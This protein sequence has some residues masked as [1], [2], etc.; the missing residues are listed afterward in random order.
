MKGPFGR[1]KGLLFRKKIRATKNRAGFK[2]YAQFNRK[3]S[4]LGCVFMIKKMSLLL[5]GILVSSTVGCSFIKIE[6]FPKAKIAHTKWAEVKSS[7]EGIYEFQHRNVRLIIRND[8][9]SGCLFF[10]G[11]PLLPV[12]PLFRKSYQAKFGFGLDV[13]SLSGRTKIDL[14]KIRIQTSEG[15]SMQPS[16]IWMWRTG[17]YY[18]KAKEIS[19]QQVEVSKE[20]VSFSINFDARESELVKY[21]A[22]DLGEIAINDENIEV[23]LL[24]YHKG[25][26]W[27]F[28][29][30]AIG[31][32]GLIYFPK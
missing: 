3:P 14:S 4:T 16:G 5:I 28:A 6:T 13:E 15:R 19:I 32:E 31:S 21:F 10:W 2:V 27:H 9:Y 1:L 8:T 18:E 12:F 22:L 11:P 17:N 29:L 20:K 7:W 23:P 30:L 26:K 25:S 24:Q